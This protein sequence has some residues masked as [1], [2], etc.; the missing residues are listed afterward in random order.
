MNLHLD[1][2]IQMKDKTLVANYL[3]S[4]LKSAA[5]FGYTKGVNIEQIV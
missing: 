2:I 1:T 5:Y 4:Y 3:S